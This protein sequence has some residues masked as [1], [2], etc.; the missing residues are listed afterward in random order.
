MIIKNIRKMNKEELSKKIDSKIS[1]I[2]ESN[3][4]GATKKLIDELLSL[5]G[6]YD[7]VPTLYDLPVKDVIKEYDFG[8]GKFVMMKKYI[9]YHLRGGLSILISPRMNGIYKYLSTMLSLKDRYDKLSKEE[10]DAYEYLF[11][12]ITTIFNLPIYAVCDDTFMA[13]VVKYIFEQMNIMYKKIYDTPLQD[14]TAEKD[15]EF[16]NEMD[17]WKKV[18]EL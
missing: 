2:L 16:E 7:I 4:K 12:G 11:L 6:Q 13:D 5:K 15:A 3:D 10:K 17:M 1:E 18:G 9:I 8:V 14:E